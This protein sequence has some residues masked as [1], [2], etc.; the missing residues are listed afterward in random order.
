[1]V[2]YKYL[3]HPHL[4]L[5]HT[6]F[7]FIF[8]I[9]NSM[10]RVEA[11]L[12]QKEQNQNHYLIWNDWMCLNTT[13]D[14]YFTV[15]FRTPIMLFLLYDRLIYLIFCKNK[16]FDIAF[17]PSLSNMNGVIVLDCVWIFFCRT[18]F[19]FFFPHNCVCPYNT[20]CFVRFRNT[21]WFGWKRH[22]N[23]SAF[24]KDSSLSFTGVH[25]WWV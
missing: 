17:N 6:Y 14:P 16:V 9:L 23:D 5:R 7:Y 20:E 1:M 2:S 25:M 13:Y 21:L 8:L 3:V 4:Y 18:L 22:R 12:Q 10:K 19:S 15:L 11:L 24:N